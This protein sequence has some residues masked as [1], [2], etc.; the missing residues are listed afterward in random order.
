MQISNYIPNNVTRFV[1]R[2]TLQLQKQSPHILFGL[3]V[4][5][6]VGSTV[7]ACRATLKLEKTA[8]EI[9][10]D[11]E[12]VKMLRA[13]R[14]L[15]KVDYDDREY[16]KDMGYVYGKTIVKVSKLYGPSVILGTASIAML[17]GSHV[18]MTRRNQALTATLASVMTA[19]DEYRARVREE[20]GEEREL[21]L[22]RAM[23]NEK[24]EEDGRNRIVKVVDPDGLSPYARL[25]D[26]ASTNYKKDPEFNRVFLQCQQEYAN[27]LLRVR[28]H[29]FL[30]DVYDMLDL[31]RS[32][33]G[34][35]VGWLKD[36]EDGDG[37]VD[38]GL[39]E[40][41]NSRFMNGMERVAILDFNVDGIVYDKI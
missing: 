12:S 34:A 28:G 2:K 5:G 31:D 25:F 35:V 30:N 18:Q 4:V 37:Y 15:H 6:I 22:H 24:V 14:T 39:F 32:S 17:T 7:L 13:D 21:E 16:Y 20:V 3:G 8:D 38:F 40:A 29:V 19:F 41:V 23:R 33:P 1:G 36:S 9:K 27:H 10:N 26:D 11:F